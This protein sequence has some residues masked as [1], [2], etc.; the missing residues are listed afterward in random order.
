MKNETGSCT[1]CLLFDSITRQVKKPT[2]GWRSQ[3]PSNSST[4]VM[5]KGWERVAEGLGMNPIGN[6]QSGNIPSK[7]KLISPR[8]IRLD[9]AHLNEKSPWAL[10]IPQPDLKVCR[11]SS[12]T[13]DIVCL[14]RAGA[15]LPH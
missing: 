10:P 13:Q 7:W 8:P 14:V 12:K 15:A 11:L 2:G 1:I 4:H 6:E 3:H 9:L 5:L